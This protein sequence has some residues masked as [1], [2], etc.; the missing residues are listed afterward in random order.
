M[1]ENL[2][3]FMIAAIISSS[4]TYVARTMNNDQNAEIQTQNSDLEMSEVDEIV[5][6]YSP[7]NAPREIVQPPPSVFITGPYYY[8]GPLDVI[9]VFNRDLEPNP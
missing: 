9:P 5:L 3:L 1:K 7:R 8:N 4:C 6:R 2:G